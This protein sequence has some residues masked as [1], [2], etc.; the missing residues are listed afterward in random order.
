MTPEERKLYN[1]EYYENNKG[2]NKEKNKEYQ[3]EW[4]QTE[5]GLKNRRITNWKL[6]GVINNDFNSLY[7][8]YLNCKNC[9][10][11]NIDLIDGNYG[12]NKRVLDH[13]HETGLFR[14]ILCCSCNV[15]RR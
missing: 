12:A 3:K 4:R 2:K 1:K 5:E 11:C 7:D 6:R 10:E 9:E 14:N 8:R 13:D 15:K